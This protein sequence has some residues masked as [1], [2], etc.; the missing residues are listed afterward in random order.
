M[1]MRGML[2]QLLELPRISTVIEKSEKS[3]Y[4]N[5]LKSPK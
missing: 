4:Q 5:L 2:V 1:I 3:M